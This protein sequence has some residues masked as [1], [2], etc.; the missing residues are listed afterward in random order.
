VTVNDK[1]H[2]YRAFAH[3]LA[4][5][6]AA[7]EFYEFSYAHVVDEW[8][9]LY[10]DDV[11]DEE[12][13]PVPEQVLAA[14]HSVGLRFESTGLNDET[15][16]GYWEH[17]FG[18]GQLDL[19]LFGWAYQVM[20]ALALEPRIFWNGLYGTE[21]I[22]VPDHESVVAPA[23]GL[24]VDLEARVLDGAAVVIRRRQAEEL[25]RQKSLYSEAIRAFRGNRDQV[26][27]ALS[28]PRTAK[29]KPAAKKK[30]GKS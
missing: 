30:G 12:D 29:K 27:E 20:D 18:G 6:R 16:D 10:T 28:T 14:L 19:L 2:G 17:R 23:L 5:I 8:E 13:V 11:P 22:F 7:N 26:R 9:D 24:L 3:P 25:T 1:I 21:L 4:Q 15:D